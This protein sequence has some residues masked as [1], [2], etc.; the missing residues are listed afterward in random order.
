MPQQ[1]SPEAPVSARRRLNAMG[2]MSWEEIM[3]TGVMAICIPLWILGGF[4]NIPS[5]VT[6]LL[7]LS[8]LLLSGVL[9]WKVPVRNHSPPSPF[10]ASAYFINEII[11]NF[12]NSAL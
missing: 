12:R 5:S 3:L 10:V 1:E 2:P 8:L 6:A 7:G 4:L 11:Y 9:Q